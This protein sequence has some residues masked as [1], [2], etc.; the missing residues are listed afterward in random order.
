MKIRLMLHDDWEIYGD[1]T[2]DPNELMFEPARRILDVCDRH[3]ARYTFFAEIGQQ[4]AMRSAAEAEHN[5]TAAVWEGLLRDAVR[6]GH[7]VQLHLH[8]QWL[9]ARY[10]AGR[11]RLDLTRCSIARLSRDEMR[12][13]LKTGADYLRNLLRPESPDYDVLAFRGGGYLVQ[14]SRDL[15]AV[16]KEIGV[17]ADVT[18]VPGMKVPDRGYGGLDFT[19]APSAIEPWYPAD[20]DL[21]LSGGRAGDLLCIPTYSRRLPLPLPVFS[22]LKNP[23]SLPYVLGKRLRDRKRAYVPLN[24]WR[25]KAAPLPDSAAGERFVFCD[26]GQMHASTVLSFVKNAVRAGRQSGVSDMPLILSTHSKQFYS[27]RNLDTILRGLAKMTGIV[28]ETTR[29]TVRSLHSARLAA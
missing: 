21:A 16:L 10:E 25:A 11:W 22:F 27:Y 20:D 26:F 29:D 9:G 24:Q 4:L 3:G 18:V 8:P 13:T 19:R 12:S 1:G 5:R 2:G 6:R 17:R 15:I 7:D 23:F 28:F 14:P